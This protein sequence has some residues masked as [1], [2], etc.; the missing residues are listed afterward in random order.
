MPRIRT[1]KPQFWDSPSTAKADLAPRLLFM[2]LWNWAD[3][4][5][6]GTAN[7]KEIEAFAFPN[8]DVTQLPRRSSR[9]SAA[10][11]P[12]FAELF[13]E[14]I[15]DYE[16]TLYEVG[17]RRFF[18]ISSFR[19]HQSKH[20]K[21]E[22]SLPG[23]EDGRIWDLASE[24]GLD[25]SPDTDSSAQIRLD[26]SR[27]SALSRRDPPLDRDRDR[28]RDREQEP[29]YPPD[30]EPSP[31]P[32]PTKRTGSEKALA[33]AA[34]IPSRSVDAYRIAEAFSDSLPTPIQSEVLAEIGV[35]ID[36]C[37]RDTI[38][39]HAI[40][41]GIREWAASDSWSP[42]QIPRFVAKASA[43]SGN[44]KPTEKALGHDAALAELL[45]EV[46]TL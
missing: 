33:R 31:D 9:N 27:N 35:Q 46:T 20:F 44:G 19:I 10:V 41:N 2:A 11:W 12:N 26:S 39:P 13:W 22:S 23:P 43:R 21:P 32:L 37:L 28:D 38:P 18:E 34:A 1:L 15:R 30:D 6:R 16:V 5:G 25:Q 24:Y 42:T 45:Q 4:A 36:K 29:P 40:A 3:D 8:D 17:G 7:L 14:T